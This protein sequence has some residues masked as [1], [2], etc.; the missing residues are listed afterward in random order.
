MLPLNPLSA[1][2]LTFGAWV[3]PYASFSEHDG[4]RAVLTLDDAAGHSARALE[5]HA[6]RWVVATGSDGEGTLVGPAVRLGEWVFV[7]VVY[8][9]ADRSVALH[10]DGEFVTSPAFMGTGRRSLRIGARGSEMRFRQ[11]IGSPQR[12]ATM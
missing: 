2:Q 11:S 6:G 8:D 4:A 5:I 9:Q 1:P 10:V 12:S 7:A 3:F